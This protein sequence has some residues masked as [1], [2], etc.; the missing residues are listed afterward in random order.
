MVCRILR[1]PKMCRAL[2]VGNKVNNIWPSRLVFEV[3]L[4][5]TTPNK[6]YSNFENALTAKMF[7]VGNN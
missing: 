3:K 4:P 1:D 2:P 7:N 6:G 5:K